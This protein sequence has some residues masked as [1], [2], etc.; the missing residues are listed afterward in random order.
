MD[1][2]MLKPKTLFNSL[3]SFNLK[4]FV[5]HFFSVTL[6]C[7]VLQC[8]CFYAELLANL[9]DVQYLKL[10]RSYWWNESLSNKSEC[11]PILFLLFSLWQFLVSVPFIHEA[12][13]YALVLR[14]DSFLYP[15]LYNILYQTLIHLD[16]AGLHPNSIIIYLCSYGLSRLWTLCGADKSLYLFIF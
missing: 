13:L 6:H 3:T 10:S 7:S 16:Y 14:S 8:K 5:F 12:S 1:F 4:N 9:L 2:L 15:H 11:L